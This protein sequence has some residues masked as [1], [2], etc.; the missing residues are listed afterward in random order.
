MLEIAL[1]TYISYSIKMKQR[2]VEKNLNSNVK[3]SWFHIEVVKDGR[4]R[5]GTQAVVNV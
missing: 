1:E 4:G 2:L 5:R 3:R